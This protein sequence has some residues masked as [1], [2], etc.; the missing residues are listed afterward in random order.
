MPKP[1][2]VPVFHSATTRALLWSAAAGLLFS[3]LNASL[4]ALSQELHPMLVQCLRYL[5][6]IAALLPWLLRDGLAAYRPKQLGGHFV[7]GAVHTVGLVLWFIALPHLALADTTAIGFSGPIF[8]MIGAA[9][10]LR[11]P[12]R[13]E[14][15]LATAIGFGGMLIVVA[16]GLS[17]QGGGYHLVMLASAPVFAASFLLTKALTRHESPGVIVLWQAI[18][19]TLFSLPLAW[20]HWQMPSAGQWLAFAACGALGSAGHYCLTRSYVQ[21]DISATQSAK[22]LELIWA[23]LQGWWLFSDLPTQTA[24]LGGTVIAAATVWLARRESRTAVRLPAER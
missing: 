9:L 4:R 6:G 11:E 21:A 3:A 5:F 10:F 20:P 18:S 8:I 23:A 16:P 14:R 2:H 12:M 13:W 1:L 19:V 7:R 24:L 15:W 22:F 17:G